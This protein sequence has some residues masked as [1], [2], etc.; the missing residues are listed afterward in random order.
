MNGK[1]SIAERGSAMS[2]E[3]ITVKRHTNSFLRW[4]ASVASVIVIVG[5]LFALYQVKQYAPVVGLIYLI[6]ICLIPVI[7]LCFLIVRFIKYLKEVEFRD[8]GP[9]GTIMRSTITGRKMEFYPLGIQEHAST[10]QREQQR[11]KEEEAID[12]P[13]MLDLLKEGLI[14][15]N[16]LLLGFHRDGSTRYGYWNDLRTFAIGGKSR[17]GKTVTMIF[18]IIQALLSGAN[19]W[20]CDPHYNKASGLSNVLKPLTPFMRVARKDHEIIQAVQDFREEMEKRLHIDEYPELADMPFTPMLLVV[21]EWTRLVSRC[22]SAQSEAIVNTVLACAEEYAGIDGYAMIAGHEWTARESGGKKGASLRRGLHA[23][24]VHRLDE[25][26]A[27][28]LLQGS[29]GKK[30]AKNAPNLPTGHMLIQDSEG[31]TDYLIIPF[32]G[33]NNEAVY[34]VA[35]M[36]KALPAPEGY[37]LLDT[38]EEI[39]QITTGKPVNAGNTNKQDVY[40]PIN[41]HVEAVHTGELVSL[42]PVNGYISENAE[43]RTEGPVNGEA[44]NAVDVKTI[45]L[46]MHK[47][48]IPLRDIAYVVSL[49]GRNYEQFKALC[50][51]LGITVPVEN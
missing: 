5:T 21:D 19:V 20:I 41:R 1:D 12:V 18:Y 10:K 26:Y 48:K 15:G 34:E 4:L 51:E 43:I 37:V 23:V 46:R 39:P 50:S 33:K 9:S 29:K 16:E 31:D 36:L 44:V 8:V 42:P 27:K 11:Q 17:S 14:G 32:A 6:A 3:Q 25:D 22:D 40:T 30:A 7:G 35:N 38:P 47:R 28:F 24:I 2:D 13:P 49:Y 45:I